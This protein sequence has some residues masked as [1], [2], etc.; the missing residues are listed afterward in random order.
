METSLLETLQGPSPYALART[1]GKE[2]GWLTTT[3]I[4]DE[5]EFYVVPYLSGFA[6]TTTLFSIYKFNDSM[7]MLLILLSR[8]HSGS[9]WQHGLPKKKHAGSW[10]NKMGSCLRTGANSLYDICKGGIF[11]AFLLSQ[12]DGW[13]PFI[14]IRSLYAQWQDLCQVK[15]ASSVINRKAYNKPV[16]LMGAPQTLPN[17]F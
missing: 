14:D 13:E 8:D 2:S 17:L 1:T 3:W 15:P 10:H 5:E 4:P 7:P 9:C 6:Y 12:V 11:R 16:L